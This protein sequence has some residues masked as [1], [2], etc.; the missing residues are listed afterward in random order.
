MKNQFSGNIPGMNVRI[1]NC[2]A[3]R[4]HDLLLNL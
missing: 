4:W 3:K 1:F 2:L